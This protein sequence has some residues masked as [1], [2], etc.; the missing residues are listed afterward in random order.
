MIIDIII[1]VKLGLRGKKW[2]HNF[3]NQITS[4]IKYVCVCTD[5][6]ALHN[7]GL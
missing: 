2:G 1:R 7:A 4:G 5:E 6:G 3:V